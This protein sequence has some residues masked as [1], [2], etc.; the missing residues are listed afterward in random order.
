[1][2]RSRSGGVGPSGK[3]HGLNHLIS[4]VA[5]NIYVPPHHSYGKLTF[6][7]ISHLSLRRSS[8]TETS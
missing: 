6:P 3:Q 2:D 7:F 5:K 4:T 8:K 1:M